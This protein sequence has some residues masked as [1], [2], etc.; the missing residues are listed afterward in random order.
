MGAAGLRFRF[1]FAFGLALR[2]G[3]AF[4]FGSARAL[5]F[6]GA[7]DLALTFAL[8]F[9]FGF[10]LGAGLG[11]GL[12]FALLFAFFGFVLVSDVTAFFF[13]DDATDFVSD[14]SGFFFFGRS[15][16]TAFARADKFRDELRFREGDVILAW[17]VGPDGFLASHSSRFR[18]FVFD[19]RAGRDNGVRLD[20][21]GFEFLLRF[22]FGGFRVDFMTPLFES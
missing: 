15:E 18:G 19:F 16:G 17:D 21:R 2:F 22:G 7:L 8:T 9:G 14:V 10:G 13:V 6:G 11:A 20:W 4:F 1:A 5:A 3:F 12:T